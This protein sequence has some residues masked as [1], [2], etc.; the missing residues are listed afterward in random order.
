MGTTAGLENT[1]H[2]AS[3]ISCIETLTNDFTR[4][5]ALGSQAFAVA[6]DGQFHAIILKPLSA[7]ACD[8]AYDMVD[9]M[10]CKGTVG[11]IG[12]RDDGENGGVTLW[13]LCYD[14]S[15][16]AQVVLLLLSC[17][18]GA[19]YRLLRHSGSTQSAL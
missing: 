13:V 14:T 7:N 19:P 8:W 4:T 17:L 10:E 5:L 2:F 9:D 3:N 1:P 12:I 6:G 11:Q 18:Q 16:I 15:K